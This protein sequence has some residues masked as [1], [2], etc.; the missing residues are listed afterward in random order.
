[1]SLILVIIPVSLISALCLFQFSGFVSG[2]VRKIFDSK[3]DEERKTALNGLEI[4]KTLINNILERAK[5]DLNS[6]AE[7]YFVKSYISLREG[8]ASLLDSSL[9]K[10]LNWM[11]DSAVRGCRL[12]ISSL[13][14]KLFSDSKAA[15]EIFNDLGPVSFDAA[16]AVAWEAENQL[17]HKTERVTLP[18]M[19]AGQTAFPPN[20]SFE[21]ESP[22]VDKIKK[23]SG[24]YCTVFQR[25]NEAGDM[26][27]VATNVPKADG[28]R[29]VGTYIPVRD[30]GGA[31]TPV[32]KEVLA[33][34]TYTG[35]AFVVNNWCESV[36]EPVKDSAGK[37]TGILF[38]GVK[39]LDDDALAKSILDVKIGENGYFYVM[40]SK[41]N[42]LLHPQK[43]LTGKNIVSDLKLN[44]LAPA[45]SDKSEG[46][47]KTLNY[48]FEGKNKF[49]VY[50]YFKP[51]DWI[52]CGGGYWDDVT[53]DMIRDSLT[54]IQSQF[55]SFGDAASKSSGGSQI[56]FY[57]QIRLIDSKGM[58]LVKYQKGDLSS[59]LKPKGDKDWFKEAMTLK[60]GDFSYSEVEMTENTGDADVRISTPV[61]VK[62]KPAALVVINLNWAFVRKELNKHVYGKTGYPYI[63]NG[64]GLVVSHPKYTFSD[65]VNMTDARHGALA[66]LVKN[67]MLSG[68]TGAIEYEFDNIKKVAA[69][70]TLLIGDKKYVITA[71][72]P[73]SEVEEAGAQI[74]SD[75]RAQSSRITVM[76]AVSGAVMITLGALAGLLFSGRIAGR[77]NSVI[78]K[79]GDC[80]SHL[81]SASG[82]ISE[83]SAHLA[84]SSSEQASNLEEISASLS[85]ISSMIER[86]AGDASAGSREMLAAK[87]KA[88]EVRKQM[89]QLFA[90]FEKIRLS[91]SE[92]AKIIKTIDEIAFQTNL[93]ALNA[94]VEAARAGEAG[95]SFAV[96]ADEVR[97][98]AV[99]AAAAARNTGGLID[100]T[101]AAVRSGAEITGE[102][103]KAIEDNYAAVE[104]VSVM[105]AKIDS[106]SQEQAKGVSQLSHAVSQLNATTQANAA[107]AEEAS[108]AGQQLRD[109]AGSLVRI[110][111]GLAEIVEGRGFGARPGTALTGQSAVS[112]SGRALPRPSD[113]GKREKALPGGRKALPGKTGPV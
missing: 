92:T 71:T 4:D 27:R 40:D 48:T 29:A 20:K 108:A 22:L 60:E 30:P 59:D 46:Q 16:G 53:K 83:T 3:L 8:G 104:K 32:L 2:S 69:F 18:L 106:A 54:H 101:V 24:A 67:R 12:Q 13:K 26:L 82:Q 55:K 102:T 97:S 52:I 37:V 39:E 88:A 47:I 89:D 91:S 14:R 58:E 85:Q 49:V 80:S 78:R 76:T 99:R 94:A 7:S 113:A 23:F 109:Q 103:K 79:L 50:T 51:W 6:L 38:T 36:Y 25:M 15:R 1:M 70:K 19:K 61:F 5:N 110:V 90:A 43:E 64:A 11:A 107:G 9:Q 77:L 98:L 65:K 57:N 96:V 42:L 56:S 73:L 111:S 87:E 112:M 74:E 34:R 17:T 81:D 28:S 105:T 63:I 35:R 72:V 93:L 21:R 95:K 86:N 68:E 45:M 33:G 44:D 41:G 31:E 100:N 62:G 75:A 10:D 84:S 66:E